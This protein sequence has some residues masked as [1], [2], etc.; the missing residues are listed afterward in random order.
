V[1]HT[2]LLEQLGRNPGWYGEDIVVLGFTGRAI[3]EDVVARAGE[4][5]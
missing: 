1:R 3:V 4:A 5:E 2:L